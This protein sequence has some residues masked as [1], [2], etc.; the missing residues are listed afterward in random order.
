[1]LD[2]TAGKIA[3]PLR[4]AE[5]KVETIDVSVNK[6]ELRHALAIAAGC[7]GEE[8]QVGEIGIARGGLGTA[9]VRCPVAGARKLA[10][11]RRVEVGWSWAT[12]TAIPKHP[13]QCFRCQELGHV[14]ATF[15]SASVATR[16]KSARQA[17]R[18]A[19]CA[20]H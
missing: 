14:R 8:I 4:R 6:E 7:K 2:P 3:A 9:W 12:V 5:L 19:P 20:K 11:E 18:T 13:L 1:V 10:R 17:S 16:P 15:T